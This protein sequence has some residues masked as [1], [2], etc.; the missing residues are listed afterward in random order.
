[1]RYLGSAPGVNG[2]VVVANNAQVAMSLRQRFDNLVLRLVCVLVL[3]DENVIKAFRFRLS[4][5]RK[6]SKQIV[7]EQKQIVEVDSA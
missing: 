2:L 1:M 5:F 7:S 4:D 3:V 6:L